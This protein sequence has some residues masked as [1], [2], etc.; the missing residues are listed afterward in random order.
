MNLLSLFAAACMA[1]DPQL[2]VS[3]DQPLQFSYLDEPLVIAVQSDVSGPAHAKAQVSSPRGKSAQEID[4]GDINLRAGEETWLA[5]PTIPPGEG[6]FSIDLSLDFAGESKTLHGGF[7]RIRRSLGDHALPIVAYGE[8]SDE[9]TLRALRSAPVPALRVDL[10]GEESVERANALVKQG[11]KLVPYLDARL[12]QHPAEVA[13]RAAE[14]WCDSVVRWQVAAGASVALIEDVSRAVRETQCP[15]PVVAVVDDIDT[16]KSL[17]ENGLGDVV[18]SVSVEVKEN[19]Q[20]TVAAVQSIAEQ[21]GFEQW[22]VYAVLPPPERGA[23]ENN[24]ITKRM[25]LALAEGFKSVAFHAREV[26][27]QGLT[28]A[29]SRLNALSFQLG[30]MDY[31]GA[32]P[33]DKGVQTVLFKQGGDWFLAIWNDKGPKDL[34]LEVGDAGKLK[35]V[36]QFNQNIDLADVSKGALPLKVDKQPL[37][38]T[39]RGGS[40]FDQAARPMAKRLASELSKRKE[41]MDVLGPEVGAAVNGVVLSEGAVNTR[42]NFF[43]MLR[44]LP[45]LERRWHAGELP[46]HLAVSAISHLARLLRQVCVVEQQRGEAFLEPLQDTLARCEE[47]QAYYLTSSRGSDDHFERGDWLLGEV[48]RLMN[49]ANSL[50]AAGRRIEASAVAALAEWRARGLEFAAAATGHEEDDNVTV[51]LALPEKPPAPAPVAEASTSASAAPAEGAHKVKKGDTLGGIADKYKV[52]LKDLMA[53][54]KLTKKSRLSIGQELRVVPPGGAPAAPAAPEAEPAPEAPKAEATPE[55]APAPATKEEAPAPTAAAE[56]GVH[57]IAKGETLATLSAKYK[58]P[59]EDLLKWNKLTKKSR[60]SIGQ[61]IKISAPGAEPPAE[62]KAPEAKREEEAEKEAP[63]AEEPEEEG[64]APAPGSKKVMHTVDRGETTRT[65][66]NKYGVSEADFRKW[67]GIR[68]GAQLARGKQYV[69]YVPQ[70]GAPAKTQPKEEAPKKEEA[71][72]AAGAPAG[73][74]QITHVV[75]RGDNP[76]IISQKYKVELDDL[77]KWNNWTKKTRLNVGDKVIV[78]TK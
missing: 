22:D 14:M 34:L 36:D 52:S 39:G 16:F 49:E 17:I 37:Y 9:A 40:L 19:G 3:P 33:V 53:W 67:N 8:E 6:F 25:F 20:W 54:N 4:L 30:E 32:L 68:A 50:A 35:A 38:I 64:A 78:Y 5:L 51:A 42:N 73:K 65:I 61:E 55:P 26:Y 46:R 21:A 76:Y 60:L 1:F 11:F 75:K 66:A 10:L 69:V 62:T 31:A 27:D 18:R 72:A 24:Y 2:L 71:K 28:P 48:R 13:K 47:Y 59:L 12:T 7:A 15:A 45:D 74:K 77:L 23:E 44:A 41:L 63:A 43:V 70:R 56:G 29:F 57:K 58:V